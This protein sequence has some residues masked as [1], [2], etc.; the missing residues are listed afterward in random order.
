MR[1]RGIR[2]GRVVD[3]VFDSDATRVLGLDVLCGDEVRR[4]LP[5]SAAEHDECG[6]LRVGSTLLLLD[7]QE[8]EFYPRHGRTRSAGGAELGDLGILRDGTAAADLAAGRSRG[9]W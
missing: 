6:D 3:V 9:R 4:F 7:A 2:L 5:F 8:R 1:W